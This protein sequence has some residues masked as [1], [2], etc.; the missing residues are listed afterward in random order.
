MGAAGIS[1]SL[2][3]TSRA[4]SERR[5]GLP[6]RRPRARSARVASISCSR[7]ARTQREASDRSAPL[8]SVVTPVFNGELFLAE[9]IESVLAQTYRP[10]ELI[11]VDDGST[12]G[13]AAIAR[14]F[15]GVRLIE[16][17]HAGPG[18]A[19]NR[20]VAAS[21][22]ELLAFL[23]AD[24]LMPPDKLELQAGYLSTHPEVGCVLGR[25]ELITEGWSDPPPPAFA[26]PM[27][28]DLHPELLERG[29]LQPLSLMARRSLFDKVGEFSTEFGEDLDWLARVWGSG[30]RVEI[31]DAVVVC[32]R[33]HD[34]NLTHAT[35]ASRLAM[36][37]ALKE[38]AARVRGGSFRSDRPEEP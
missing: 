31:L 19:R 11:I 33:V 25:Q 29:S 27:S 2:A 26:P 4:S 17:E 13:S 8:V 30:A 35:R 21:A 3:L 37:R 28:P 34:A 14:S 6:E 22:G 38:H 32:R 1:R 36:F 5:R 10:L 16:Q 7:M 23:D 15:Q 20:G 9:A 24:D 12:D 18:A